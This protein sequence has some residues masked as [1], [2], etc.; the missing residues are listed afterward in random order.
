[1]K[2]LKMK[3]LSYEDE[4]DSLIVSFASSDN[5]SQNPEDYQGYAYQPANMWPDVTDVEEIKERI[6]Q[7]GL[8]VAEQQKRRE[9]LQA[10][11]VKKLA[12]RSLV[13][14]TFEY[15][16]DDLGPVDPNPVTE[17]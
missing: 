16:F 4:T 2:T 3:V 12:L 13:G 14:N 5:L 10:D 8:Y 7:S 17:L 6:A 11:P 15:T 9:V 1:M